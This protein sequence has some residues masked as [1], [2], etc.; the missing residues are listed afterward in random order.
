MALLGFIYEDVFP[1]H[2]NWRGGVTHPAVIARSA[3]VDHVEPVA[4]GGA[5]LAL[6]NLVTACNPCNSIKADFSLELLGWELQRQSNS[7]WDGLLR[8]YPGLWHEAGSPN[9]EYHLAWMADLGVESE[10]ER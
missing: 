5:P 2:P 10:T 1:W 9:P 3:V 6:E 8:F 7:D 4:T